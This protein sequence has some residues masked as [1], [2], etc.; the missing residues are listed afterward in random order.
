MRRVSPTNA[1]GVV[2]I[3]VAALIGFATYWVTAYPAKGHHAF[4]WWWPTNWM[5]L[6]LAIVF[7]GLLLLTPARRTRLV[8]PPPPALSASGEFIVVRIEVKLGQRVVV[9]RTRLRYRPDGR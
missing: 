9:R 7:V 3:G 5:A 8:V 1:L 6:P 2:A 4:H